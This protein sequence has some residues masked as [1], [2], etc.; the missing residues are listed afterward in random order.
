MALQLHLVAMVVIVFLL[1]YFAHLLNAQ[2]WRRMSIAYILA[3]TL[4]CAPLIWIAVMRLMT[5]SGHIQPGYDVFLMN[6]FVLML[7]SICMFSTYMM[8]YA[9][10][11]FFAA[12]RQRRIAIRS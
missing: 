10:S 9:G 11:M 8:V 4:I 12:L 6:V 5:Q 7:L 3:I 1:G 2:G